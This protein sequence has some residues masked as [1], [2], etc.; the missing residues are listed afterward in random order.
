MPA[1]NAM[2][3]DGDRKPFDTRTCPTSRL[4]TI[5]SITVYITILFHFEKGFD[6]VYLIDCLLKKR[7]KTASHPL[8]MSIRMSNFGGLYPERGPIITRI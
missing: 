8:R 5:D 4:S 3:A 6:V 7:E 2:A 1:T